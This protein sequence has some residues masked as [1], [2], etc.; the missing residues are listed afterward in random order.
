MAAGSQDL[1]RPLF[2][3]LEG[4]PVPYTEVVQAGRLL[5]EALVKQGRPVSVAGDGPWAGV[6]SLEHL[7]D[8][9]AAAWGMWVAT[10]VDRD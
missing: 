9:E 10:K 6:W 3:A 5:A 1:L 2:K 8:A 4:T 7:T